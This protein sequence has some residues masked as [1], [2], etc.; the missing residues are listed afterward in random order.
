MIKFK[1]PC[2]VHATERNTGLRGVI[3]MLS[4]RLN[5]NI[6]YSLQPP[7]KEGETHKREG[8]WWV[9]EDSLTVDPTTQIKP[10]EVKFGFTVG[11]YVE[12][13]VS[14]IKGTIVRATFHENGCIRYEV[15]SKA[16]KGVIPS[17][18]F[19][20][21]R[22]LSIKPKKKQHTMSTRVASIDDGPGGPSTPNNSY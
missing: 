12:D 17:N 18:H 2:G 14:G 16:K 22:L 3:D 10:V 4:I 7:C 9:D 20:E 19:D 5:G 1:Y 15:E 13:I 8:S 21:I 6:Q 11:D